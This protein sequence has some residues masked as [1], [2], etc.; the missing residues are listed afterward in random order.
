MTKANVESLLAT[1]SSVQ[2]LTIVARL[3]HELTVVARDCYGEGNEPGIKDTNRLRSIN[4][5]MHHL[6]GVLVELSQGNESR[7]ASAITN[8]F[9]AERTDTR[10]CDLLTFCINRVI[11]A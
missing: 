10:L 4:E 11:P 3:L 9:F 6:T 7:V 5:I 8:T 2:K 1:A